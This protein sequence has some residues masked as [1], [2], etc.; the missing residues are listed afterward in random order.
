[1]AMA[2]PA[3]ELRGHLLGLLALAGEAVLLAERMDAEAHQAAARMSG[4]LA[5]EGLRA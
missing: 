4:R 2:W 3:V 1:M 5:A